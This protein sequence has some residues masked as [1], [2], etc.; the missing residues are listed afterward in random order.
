MPVI[1]NVLVNLI[2]RLPIPAMIYGSTRCNDPAG[3]QVRPSQPS[4]GA[5]AAIPA[6]LSSG[7]APMAEPG[8]PHERTL[9]RVANVINDSKG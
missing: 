3:R 6:V 5:A 4:F 9:D 1:E 8:E 2:A 7:L